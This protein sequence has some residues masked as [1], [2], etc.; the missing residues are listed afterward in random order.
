MDKSQER[1][2]REEKQCPPGWEGRGERELGDTEPGRRRSAADPS[3]GGRRGSSVGLASSCLCFINEFYVMCIFVFFS[4]A[5]FYVGCHRSSSRSRCKVWAC[6]FLPLAPLQRGFSAAS[7]SVRPLVTSL[8][9]SDMRV[10]L[11]FKT[12]F[13]AI[14]CSPCGRCGCGPPARPYPQA[15]CRRRQPSLTPLAVTSHHRVPDSVQAVPSRERD[16][17]PADLVCSWQSAA[18]AHVL[19]AFR[20]FVPNSV[21]RAGCGPACSQDF[22]AYSIFYQFCLLGERSPRSSDLLEPG[23]WPTSKDPWVPSP[24]FPSPWAPVPLGHCSSR[25]LPLGPPPP[26]VPHLLSLPA[27]SRSPAAPLL[28][29]GV[30]KFHHDVPQC[31]S[32]HPLHWGQGALDLETYVL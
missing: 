5:W 19:S 20:A 30:L 31:E 11:V 2:F 6:A 15:S 1:Y 8:C 24:W 29:P 13:G 12:C 22:Q 23:T 25:P 4:S 10:L 17:C 16:A 21:P 18:S 28:P 26:W 14:G 32:F 9:L 3:V 7:C 27:G